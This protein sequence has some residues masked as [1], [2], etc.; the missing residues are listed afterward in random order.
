MHS[1]AFVQAWMQSTSM[2]LT[3]NFVGVAVSKSLV[4]RQQPA[5]TEMMGS[6]GAQALGATVVV[7]MVVSVVVVSVVVVLVALVVVLSV[8]VVLLTVVVVVVVITVVVVV[9]TVVVVIHMPFA[10]AQHRPVPVASHP[11]LVKTVLL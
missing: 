2:S 8:V 5:T 9:D 3:L 10:I 6:P 1:A 7:V 4:G 11:Q